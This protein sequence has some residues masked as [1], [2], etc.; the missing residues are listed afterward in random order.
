MGCGGSRVDDGPDYSED[1][2]PNGH[3]DEAPPQLL[4]NGHKDSLYN[5]IYSRVERQGVDGR[6]HIVA[7]N[8]KAVYRNPHARFVYYYAA[9]EGGTAGWSFDHRDQ[10]DSLGSKDF[11]AGGFIS[12]SGGPAYPP[13][14]L[15]LSLVAGDDD[16]S[17]S[18]S[19]SDD[20][21]NG[22]DDSIG[23]IMLEPAKPPAAVCISGHT[24]EDANDT[25]TL[26][27]DLWN[28]QPHYQ[29]AR[30]V[31]FYYYAANEGGSRGWA[32]HPLDSTARWPVEDLCE[33]GWVG[34]NLWSHPP[35][36]DAVGFNTIGQCTVQ[37]VGG[38][39]AAAVD[40]VYAQMLQ[41]RQQLVQAA[42]ASVPM[43]VATPAPL[44]AA[45]AVPTT[46]LGAPPTAMM[47]TT[48]VTTTTT[49]VQQGGMPVLMAQ[50]MDAPTVMVQAVPS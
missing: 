35:L 25:Y 16:N 37:A 34:P 22:D 29:S 49:M 38:A 31:H 36:G 48:T 18:E 12:L 30:G 6:M 45:V 50:P 24:E 47:Q 44:V 32:L 40:Q 5:G 3:L 21:P 11:Y 41:E 46:M 9:N 20:G 43:S 2:L 23:V 8:G 26:A 39:S 7:W 17:S 19:G 1:E 4:I 28:G 15:G 42:Q 10:P 33:Y 14:G 27:N 13:I